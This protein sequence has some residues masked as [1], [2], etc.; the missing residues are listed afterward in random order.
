MRRWSEDI[1][2]RPG[3]YW[4]ALRIIGGDAWEVMIL[5]ISDD[6]GP[7]L[8][9][10]SPL[11]DDSR[12]TLEEWVGGVECLWSGPLRHPGYPERPSGREARP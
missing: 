2:K 4:C 7:R 3:V 12:M 11:D 1:P 8:E 5:E 6:P 9:V 10:L